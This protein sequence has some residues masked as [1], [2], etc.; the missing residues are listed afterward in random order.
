MLRDRSRKVCMLG[1]LRRC[2]S[3]V[4]VVDWASIFD[5]LVVLTVLTT[6]R[7]SRLQVRG[8]TLSMISWCMV[9]DR[10]AVSCTVVPLFT[11]RLIMLV[12]LLQLVM[13]CVRLFVSVLQER[14]LL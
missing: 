5:R 7:R 3:V 9:V 12:G 6:V 4:L 11:E 13:M 14:L 10:A 2:F 8:V 1:L